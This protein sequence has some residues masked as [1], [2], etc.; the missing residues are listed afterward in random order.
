MLSWV[1]PGNIT[2]GIDDPREGALLEVAGRL[3]SIVKHR[4]FGGWVKE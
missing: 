2:W 3:K 1:G 4:I